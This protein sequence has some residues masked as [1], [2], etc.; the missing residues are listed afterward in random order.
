MSTVVII[1]CHNH[2]IPLLQVLL[3]LTRYQLPC[4]VVDDGSDTRN[5]KALAAI[6]RRHKQEQDAAAAPAP[7]AGTAAGSAA[8]SEGL[9]G[10]DGR[11]P[12]TLIVL[13]HR[14]NL[15]KGA[16]VL[17]ALKEARRL[18]YSHALQVDADGQHD[19]NDIPRFL[20]LSAQE[21][22]AL[23][24]GLP[25]YGTDIP[26]GRLY[27]RKITDFWVMLETLSCELKDSMC[28]YRIYPVA[29][30]LELMEHYK[31]GLRMDFDIEILVRFYWQ[32]GTGSVRYLPT[33]VI[34]PE[35][36]SSNF[37]MFADNVSISLM[38][39]RLF[40]NA[41]F[42]LPGR[43]KSRF[44]NR[45]HAPSNA[46]STSDHKAATGSAA[47][48][49]QSHWSAQKELKGLSG[50][51]F[52]VR[53]QN[54]MG[55]RLSQLLLYPTVLFYY[56][57]FPHKR[58]LSRRFLARVTWYQATRNQV[59]RSQVITKAEDYATLQ[60][61][62]SS[63]WNY[64]TSAR[65]LGSAVAA[66]P[67]A[68]AAPAGQHQ[69][70]TMSPEEYC[71]RLKLHL[72]GSYLHFC[73][74]AS[75]M[76]DKF[77]AWQE[78][79]QPG[80]D[81]VFAPGAMELLN[82]CQGKGCV[83]LTSHLG[84]IDAARALAASTASTGT[85]PGAAAGTGGAAG[86]ITVNALVYEE[87]AAAFREV[88]ARFAPRSRFNLIPVDHFGPHT[89]MLMQDKL[90]RNEWVAIAGDRL[91][92]H[93]GHSSNCH[94]VTCSFLGRPAPF[95][96]GPFLMAVLMK[97][98]I[99]QMF[100]LK[101]R[102]VITIYVHRLS[103]PKNITRSERTRAVN[104]LIC[105]YVKNLETY[106]CRYPLEWFNFYDFWHLPQTS[107]PAN[108]AARAAA[109]QAQSQQDASESKGGQ[110]RL[111]RASQDAQEAT[112]QLPTPA[113]AG[114]EQ[115]DVAPKV[116]GRTLDSKAT[117]PEKKGRSRTGAITSEAATG[118]SSRKARQS[119]APAR[120]SRTSAR[121]SRAAAAGKAAAA[122]GT[123]SSGKTESSQR[124]SQSRR[125]DA[126]FE[127]K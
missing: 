32:E 30:T 45:P 51:A 101:D 63:A 84:N 57:C 110:S 107:A 22:A 81:I 109:L 117:S 59:K 71:R 47:W 91:S 120:S 77:C 97:R 44:Q 115:T 99:L 13:Q 7:A 54:L 1:P 68:S 34:Y 28:G 111:K 40:L 116:N 123:A 37:K 25:Q 92:L 78:Q 41:L 39:A 55:R 35:D 26:K 122:A 4:I 60:A 14:A 90:E 16:A 105:A 100:A 20:Q 121:S 127:L 74:F 38:H 31:I 72:P 79:L 87:N 65:T 6:I 19:L 88:M 75:S 53:L 24:S 67:A 29:A 102:G 80:R 10:D 8:A 42:H 126:A 58:K 5:R 64:S 119:K 17:T 86:G 52:L 43:L 96:E 2:V 106:A 18:G 49:G 61:A 46:N 76:L 93:P 95:A 104:D 112:A 23:I 125:R 33:K 85:T 108:A 73:H 82:S 15:G 62:Q 103:V 118:E 3:Q 27:G 36:G 56:L 69:A 70:E 114:A 124:R 94:S 66:A 11:L 21:P 98:D 83:L 48:T 89:A 9:S 12:D 50:L 113:G